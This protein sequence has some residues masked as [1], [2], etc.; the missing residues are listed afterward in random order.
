MGFFFK[1]PTK[2]GDPQNRRPPLALVLNLVPILRIGVRAGADVAHNRA[3]DFHR[4]AGARIVAMVF[5]DAVFSTTALGGRDAGHCVGN[6]DVATI[7]IAGIA[8]RRY[9]R[10][11]T[12]ACSSLISVVCRTA[13][14][15]HSSASD[16]N[17]AACTY[18]SC[19][20]VD[21]ATTD[22]CSTA[23]AYGCH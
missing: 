3:A 7:A 23:T 11:S 18:A 21:A 4:A 20:T 8:A 14:S 13:S 2:K 17:I 15:Y 12:Y 10:T 16:A 5:A 1:K 22:T 9:C 6:S 19:V